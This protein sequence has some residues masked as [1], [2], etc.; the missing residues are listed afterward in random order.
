MT[1][2]VRKSNP[3]REFFIGLS[4]KGAKESIQD[5]DKVTRKEKELEDQVEKT[6]TDLNKQNNA[7]RNMGEGVRRN[8]PALGRL[9][10]SFSGLATSFK[11]IGSG[12]GLKGLATGAKLASSAFMGVLGIAKSIFGYISQTAA[13]LGG[14]LGAQLINFVGGTSSRILTKSVEDA[15]VEESAIM[16][17]RRALFIQGK[18]TQS[19]EKTLTRTAARLQDRLGISAD[20]I[21]GGVSRTFIASGQDPKLANRVAIAATTLS[22]ITG[23]DIGTFFEEISKTFIMGSAGEILTSVVPALKNLTEEQF[24]SSMTLD[25][26]EKSI[27]NFAS[28]TDKSFARLIDVLSVRFS[29]FIKSFGRPIRDALKTIVNTMSFAFADMTARGRTMPQS[30]DV[31]VRLINTFNNLFKNNSGME[32][33]FIL[34]DNVMGKL[35]KNI[36]LI[37]V[38]ITKFFADPKG[39]NFQSLI[40]KFLQ[41][42]GYDRSIGG[43][44]EFAFVEFLK[45]SMKVFLKALGKVIKEIFSPNQEDLKGTKWFNPFPAPNFFG[46]D[47]LLQRG[48]PALFRNFP[49]P[50]EKAIDLFSGSKDE[51]EEKEK[52]R[53]ATPNP[54]SQGSI[55]INQDIKISTNQPREVLENSLASSLMQLSNMGRLA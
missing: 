24:K 17:L 10:A 13:V 54:K 33:Y 4:I 16:E 20:D 34:L 11:S 32:N 2:L 22:D 52:E 28:F 31:L 55:S 43:L 51:E 53:K 35:F 25:V 7:F 39:G 3:L 40:G 29:E 45:I 19:L 30:T 26:I 23:K 41:K 49:I 9:K 27:G 36:S 15:T 50:W 5:L 47:G 12:G 18:Y 1:Q 44:L 6:T 8:V 48:I 14:I 46:K 38:D 42:A 21:I 37:V